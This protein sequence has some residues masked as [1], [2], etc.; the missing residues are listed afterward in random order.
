MNSESSDSLTCWYYKFAGYL[1]SCDFSSC[2]S[3]ASSSATDDI[4]N[5]FFLRPLD[6][7]G[8]NLVSWPLTSDDYSTLLHSMK[9]VSVAKADGFVNGLVNRADASGAPMLLE[10]QSH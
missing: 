2:S 10:W 6:N 9:M 3:M 4:S 7:P 8:L 5:S 1:A